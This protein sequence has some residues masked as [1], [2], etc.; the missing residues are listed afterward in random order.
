MNHNK[1]YKCLGL[2]KDNI[3]KYN[4]TYI[5]EI[6]QYNLYIIYDLYSYPKLIKEIINNQY[7]IEYKSTLNKYM[8]ELTHKKY[9]LILYVSYVN[10]DLISFHSYNIKDNS[11]C[12]ILNKALIKYLL[13][14]NDEY[15]FIIKHCL[16]VNKNKL[17]NLKQEYYNTTKLIIDLQ[18]KLNIFK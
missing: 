18:K 7:D 15:N 10:Y 3:C 4:I 9:D 16:H 11:L 13:E 5:G 12:N 6:S 17:D 1:L 2:T 8:L 14:N